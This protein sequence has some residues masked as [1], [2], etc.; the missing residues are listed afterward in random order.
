MSGGVKLDICYVI[1][2]IATG[3]VMMATTNDSE[4]WAMHR[5]VKS[6]IVQVFINKNRV[7]C[8]EPKQ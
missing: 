3:E 1:T 7:A 8:V 2:H 5:D 6:A 4:A